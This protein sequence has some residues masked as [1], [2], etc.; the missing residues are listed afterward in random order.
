MKR[1]IILALLIS[2]LHTIA[3]CD[4]ITYVVTQDTVAERTPSRKNLSKGDI[5]FF[6][7]KAGLSTMTN[8]EFAILIRTEGGSEWYIN[9]NHVLLQDNEPL[10]DMIVTRRWIY[11]FYQ[12]IIF[13]N[14]RE[15]LYKYEPFWRDEYEEYKK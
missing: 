6:W 13:E 14:Q 11:S 12:N 7:G 8:T 1:K 10:P 15:A 3:Y 4:T 9:A 2:M 5:V